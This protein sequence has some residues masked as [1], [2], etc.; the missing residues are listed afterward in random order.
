MTE[1][2]TLPPVKPTPKW[3][4]LLSGALSWAQ[5]HPEIALPTIAF[6][7]GCVMGKWVL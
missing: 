6:L 5:S 2:T 7:G 4:R 3:K 1:E